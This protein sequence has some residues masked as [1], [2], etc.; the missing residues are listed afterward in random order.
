MK[1]KK[2]KMVKEIFQVLSL[3]LFL[4]GF[5]KHPLTIGTDSVSEQT[6]RQS[7]NKLSDWERQ[8]IWEI[9]IITSENE[10][11][12][13]LAG[14]RPKSALGMCESNSGRILLR[15]T[16][17]VVVTEH[18]ILHEIGH[19]VWF[20]RLKQSER[21]SVAELFN[22]AKKGLIPFPTKYSA[23]NKE[24]FFAESF[25]IAKGV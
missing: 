12:A 22:Q 19:A 16:P 18:N 11:S 2:A 5:A 10:W 1:M 17:G 8:C 21:D 20:L 6:I 7:I 9:R 3:S 15:A 14:Y 24:E 13:E 25:A 23:K 4:F